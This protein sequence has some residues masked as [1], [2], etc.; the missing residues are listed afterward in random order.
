MNSDGYAVKTLYS[1][2]DL[3]GNHYRSKETGDASMSG[4]PAKVPYH[5]Q[6]LIESDHY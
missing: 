1:C 5:V 3:Q 6:K 2:L 4:A